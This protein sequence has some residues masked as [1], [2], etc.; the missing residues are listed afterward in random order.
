MKYALFIA[1]LIL[2][3][4]FKGCTTL[5]EKRDAREKYDPFSKHCREGRVFILYR[6]SINRSNVGITQLL[7]GNGLPVLCA[8]EGW[9]E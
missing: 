1:F 4:L 3:P 6:P 5:C 2:F 9:I 7:D 8:E